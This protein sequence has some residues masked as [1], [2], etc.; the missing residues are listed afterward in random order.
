[1]SIIVNQAIKL[2]NYFRFQFQL[3]PTPIFSTKKKTTSLLWLFQSDK[4]PQQLLNSLITPIK[5]NVNRNK[6]KYEKF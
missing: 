4:S 5:L 3:Q 1:M 2:M 6:M